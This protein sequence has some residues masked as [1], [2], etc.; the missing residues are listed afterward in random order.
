[1]MGSDDVLVGVVPSAR[2]RV[3]EGEGKGRSLFQRRQGVGR[4]QV[5]SIPL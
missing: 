4:E 3:A 1:M 5:D 2:T